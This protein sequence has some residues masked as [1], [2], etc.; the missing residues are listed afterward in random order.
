[1]NIKWGLKYNKNQYSIRVSNYNY[2]KN[3]WLQPVTLKFVKYGVFL[4]ILLTYLQIYN[5]ILY[6]N[7]KRY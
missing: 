5:C 7:E 1:M 6:D 4:H 2:L 3:I